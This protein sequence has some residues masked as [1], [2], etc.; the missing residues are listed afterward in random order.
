MIKIKNSNRFNDLV[1][2]VKDEDLVSSEGTSKGNQEKWKKDGYWIKRNFLGYESLAEEVSSILMSCVKNLNH[3]KYSR[4]KVSYKGITSDDYCCSK[5]FLNPG[6]SI[7]NVG[8]LIKSLDSN[9]YSNLVDLH[10]YERAKKIIEFINMETGFNITN[11]LGNSIYLDSLI[12]N[13]DRHLFNLA[14]IKTNEGYTECPVFDNGLSL[15]S[16]LREYPM[17]RKLIDNIV[18]CKSRPFSDSFST[19]VRMFNELGV[20][21]LEV[22][23]KSFYNRID[24]LKV[25]KKEEDFLERC[26]DVLDYTSNKLE[27]YSWVTI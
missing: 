25:S 7:V 3:V 8:R 19:Q 16:D 2:S 20:P 13:E 12:L 15:L 17:N 11:Y 6:E 26:L 14:L 21:P 9:L 5:D 24:K 10:S 27:G 1:F 18:D 4:C 22:D 23:F